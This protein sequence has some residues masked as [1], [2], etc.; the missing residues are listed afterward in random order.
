MA[1]RRA[2]P[3]VWGREPNPLLLFEQLSV[4]AARGREHVFHRRERDSGRTL[5]DAVEANP[6]PSFRRRQAAAEGNNDGGADKDH[7]SNLEPASHGRHRLL[8]PVGSL[9]KPTLHSIRTAIR[10]IRTAIRPDCP[11]ARTV[12]SPAPEPLL[13]CD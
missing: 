11:F 8:Y 6:P 2:R 13:T 5:A 1:R 7:D 12:S 4:L 9:N 10:S 3:P